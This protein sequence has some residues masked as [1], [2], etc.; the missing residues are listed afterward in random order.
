MEI[1]QLTNFNVALKNI[2]DIYPSPLIPSHN[3][4]KPNPKNNTVVT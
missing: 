1:V 2:A 4:Q 3:V